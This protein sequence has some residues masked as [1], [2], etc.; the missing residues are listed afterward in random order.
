[1]ADV[2]EMVLVR[3]VRIETMDVAAILLADV[4]VM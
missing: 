4:P 3:I 1:M 2:V